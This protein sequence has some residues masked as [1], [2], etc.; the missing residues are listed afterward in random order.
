MEIP[1]AF[2]EER[3]LACRTTVRS[4][5]ARA[6]ATVGDRS[7]RSIRAEDLLARAKAET[8]AAYR[9]LGKEAHVEA[10][11]RRQE[12]VSWEAVADA[13][14]STVPA[15]RGWASRYGDKLAQA[16]R[17]EISTTVSA[18]DLDSELAYLSR[19]LRA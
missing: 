2:A 9:A 7:P 11:E 4:S 3:K 1:I 5:Q 13:L 8:L 14:G 18:E 16:V 17:S 10:F 19:V 6:N 15:V 12:G